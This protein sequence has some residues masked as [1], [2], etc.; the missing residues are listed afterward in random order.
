MNVVHELKSWPSF[1]RPIVDGCR[2]HELRRNDRYFNVG[3]Q[4]ILREYEPEC[5]IYTGSTCLVE[6]S[7]ITSKDTPCAV[8]ESALDPDFCILSIKLISRT[9][10]N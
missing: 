9:E 5:K 3:D 7:S 2:M 4:L 10:V 8:S 1:F 6:V